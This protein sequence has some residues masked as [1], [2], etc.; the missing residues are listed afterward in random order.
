MTTLSTASLRGSLTEKGYAILP[1]AVSA[2]LRDALLIRASELI[3]EFDPESHRSIF[4]TKEQERSSDAYFLDSANDVRF[5]FEE[6]A[7]D[8]QGGLRQPK[9]QSINKIGHAQ[10]RLDHIYRAFSAE[11]GVDSLARSAGVAQPLAIQSM[12]IFKQPRI[13]GEVGLHQDAT[14]L[15][16]NPISVV[17]LWFALEDATVENGCLWALPGAHRLGLERR[18]RRHKEGF[19]FDE[20][21]SVQ[22]PESEAVPLEVEAGTL[23]VLHGL[24]P[25]RSGPNTSDRSRQAYT[26]HFIDQGASYPEDNWLQVR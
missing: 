24:L 22:W 9:H 26:L 4:T 1:G 21:A 10:H 17:G 25:H 16:T 14:F 18:Y 8:E 23:I 5:F 11:L 19:V 15:Y 12:H 6:D 20:L 2:D 3:D 13:G 7:F